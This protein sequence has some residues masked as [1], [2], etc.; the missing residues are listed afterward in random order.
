MT[1]MTTKE[2]EAFVRKWCE[3]EDYEHRADAMVAI[4]LDDP[5]FWEASSMW[6]LLD[7]AREGER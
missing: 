5:E 7:A 1:T 3:R 4:A 2:L 6:R